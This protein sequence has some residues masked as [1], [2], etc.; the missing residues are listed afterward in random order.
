MP[1]THAASAPINYS[2]YLRLD[3]LLDCQHLE[4]AKAGN[5]AHD[6]MVFI[7]THQT[8]EP[9]FKQIPRDRCRPRHHG[10]PSSPSENW[11]RCCAIRADR[12][13]PAGAD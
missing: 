9:W 6:E 2:G 13:H 11:A 10:Q 4:S 1:K 5:P 7:V 8:Y 3:T 12:D